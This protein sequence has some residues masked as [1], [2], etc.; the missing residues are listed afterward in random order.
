MAAAWQRTFER[1]ATTQNPTAVDVLLFALRMGDEAFRAGALSALLRRN[2]P[3]AN[4][5]ILRAC[6]TF[7]PRLRT[8][9]ERQVATLSTAVRQALMH[10]DEALRRN[11]LL[12]A[13]WAHD[14][15]QIPLLLTLLEQPPG[16]LRD[17]VVDLLKS[18]IDTLYATCGG[19]AILAT[20]PHRPV[21]IPPAGHPAIRDVS[22]TRHKV[23]AALEASC[24]RYEV[25]GLPEVV[26]WLLLLGE[27]Q[28]L[29]T[30]PVLADNRSPVAP[31]AH[32]VLRTSKHP[33]IIALLLRLMSENYPASWAVKTFATR[34]DPEFLAQMLRFWP[35]RLS[36]I[37]QKNFREL[38]SVDWLDPFRFHLDLI[39]PALHP[40]LV[41]VLTALGVARETRLAVLEWI[42]RNGSPE[43][44]LAATEF[45]CELEDD[46]M[47]EVVL[48]GLSSDQ[49]GIQAWA[50]S[51][52][53]SCDVPNC[54]ELLVERLDSPHAEVRDAARAE[55]QDFGV[56]R[57]LETFTEIDP[58]R[59]AAVGRLLLKIDPHAVEKLVAEMEHPVRRR[60]I[61][62]AR[63]ALA[64]G[65]HHG[66]VDGLAKMLQDS[67][68]LVRRT[69]VE[70][71]AVIP[72]RNARDLLATAAADPSPR[73]REEIR[74]CLERWDP[75]PL[76]DSVSPDVR[77]LARS[78]SE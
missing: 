33:A 37:Q 22:R 39:P 54:F 68:I 24:Q 77:G 59:H 64:L 23:L 32:T 36:P 62:A 4:S 58:S 28:D 18:L 13:R 1:L 38:T 10:G 50:T 67:D 15:Q 3:R 27:P 19:E 69:A 11:A 49:P 42:V 34:N 7:P 14:L 53:R 56:V 74:R 65:V 60:R 51:Q 40:T 63:C 66:T 30:R 43:G 21:A 46:K 55:L 20:D 8:L 35:R 75:V 25:H 47:Q 5:E 45:L 2:S 12:V 76:A 9:L 41:R 26:E 70:V 48:G 29:L 52:L 72:S 31:V 71:L 16:P 17:Q 61:R 44:R 57:L 6:H 78:R 73:V